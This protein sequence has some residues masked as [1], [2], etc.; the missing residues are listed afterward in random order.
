MQPCLSDELVLAFVE[1][2]LQATERA[3]LEAHLG[4]CE[5]C[6]AFVAEVTETW[7]REQQAKAEVR[8]RKP[9]FEAGQQVGPYTIV[10]FAGAGGMG[11]VYR[12]SD[13]RLGR[14]VAIKTLPA[15]FADDAERLARFRLE[16][17]ATGKIGHPNA[18]TIFD[19]GSH[20]QIPYLVTEW[21]TGTTLEERLARGKKLP[22]SQIARLGAQLARA[23]GAAH[24]QGIVHRDLKPAN[25]FLCSDGSCK[26]LDF[27]LAKLAEVFEDF[28]SGDALEPGERSMLAGTPGYMSPERIRGE[29]V[30]ARADL[31]ALGAVLYEMM[32]GRKAFGGQDPMDRMTATL[33]EEPP[34]YAPD[35]REL[36]TIIARCLAKDP[37]AR[38]RSAHDLAFHLEAL[39]DREEEAR[40]RPSR[41]KFILAAGLG[42][43]GALG[44]S[45]AAALL[46][47]RAGRHGRVDAMTSER[48][49]YRPL[50]F[51]RGQIL[52][53]RF[54]RDGHTVV[55]SAS[56]DGG[57]AQLYTTRID[58]PGSKALGVS[59]DVCALSSR[60]ELALLLEPEFYESGDPSGTLARM[61]LGGGAPRAVLENAREA[62][63]SPDGNQLAAVSK[64][65]VRYR[66]E[67]PLGTVRYDG[68]SW[69]SHIRISPR[70]DSIALLLHRDP[71]D[72]AGS[73]AVLE[74][75]GPPRELST[76]WGSIRGLAFGPNGEEIWFTAART[77]TAYS[78]WAVDGQGRVRLIDRVPG[79]LLLQDIAADG[80]VL[81]DSKEH[82]TALYAGDAEGE[83]DLTWSDSS[84]LTGLS[85]DGRTMVYAAED[86][87]EGPDYGAYLRTTDGA[88]PIRLADGAAIALSPDGRW[89]LVGRK[90]PPATLSLVPTGAGPLRRLALGKLAT[91]FEG[92]FFP[93]G[94]RV[95]LRGIEGP[96]HL[97]R[98]WIHELGDGEPEPITPE[99]TAPVAVI[100][101][102]GDRFVGVDPTGA[103]RI[104]GARGEDF[105]NVP[106]HFPDEIAVGFNEDGSSLY[107]RTRRMPVRVSLVALVSGATTPHLTLPV[108]GLRPGLVSIMT[109]F[110]SADGRSYAYCT[111][112]S[113]SRLYV[114]EGVK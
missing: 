59:A 22:T 6:S 33:N 43:I 114:V 52:S 56:W 45:G 32:A 77:G 113:L 8:H 51:A 89:A 69:L 30:D 76:G 92:R 78:L 40:A 25:I 80:K 34:A 111:N 64:T 18:V 15:R 96:G 36:G 105:G 2:R 38:F 87:D 14:D 106:G 61:S 55:Y 20:E 66:L 23:L 16:A 93:D 90:S 4:G 91:I 79:G 94:R 60:G 26:I 72:D 70:G 58:A 12:A 42:A 9:D 50:T 31:F 27:G 41:R 84:Y 3:S 1:D 99:G 17:R 7:F 29:G 103:L 37:A 13:P 95:L 97:P 81:L 107:L 102:R 11:D 63:W 53:A 68:E 86:A 88:P 71:K 19:V 74:G 47:F 62:D 54:S 98:M 65:G 57:H 5:Q 10:A 46:G 44:A 100:S 73:V 28:A 110:L 48:P 39:D 112:E 35:P 67:F 21:L 83:R 85:S 24:D 104:F 75:N 108:G 101:P 109:L 82:R 49:V